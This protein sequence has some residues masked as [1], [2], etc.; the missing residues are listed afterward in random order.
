MTQVTLAPSSDHRIPQKRRNGDDDIDSPGHYRRPK[1]ESISRNSPGPNSNHSR[2]FACPFHI[3]APEKYDNSTCAHGGWRDIPRLKEHLYRRHYHRRITC[4]RCSKS[5][6]QEKELFAHRRQA[7]PC[8][9]AEIKTHNPIVDGMRESTMN[10]LKSRKRSS[11]ADD[12]EKWFEIWD[13]VFPDRERPDSPC[14]FLR[15]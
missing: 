4:E 11:T 14:K 1:I 5:F 3:A 12:E 9:V 15:L 13:A 2:R 10:L 7:V 8:P 6:P